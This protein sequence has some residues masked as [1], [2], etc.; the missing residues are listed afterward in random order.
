MVRVGGWW[1]GASE[2]ERGEQKCKLLTRAITVFVLFCFFCGGDLVAR[3]F[4][5][6]SRHIFYTRN[7][8]TISSTEGYS[9][10]N[11]FRTV[12]KIQT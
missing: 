11:I 10:M 12:F 4:E 5:H 3:G 2:G 6:K 9:L 8:V 7:I 1:S